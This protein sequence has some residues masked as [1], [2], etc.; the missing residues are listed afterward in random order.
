MSTDFF[1]IEI[2]SIQQETDEAVVLTLAIPPQLQQQFTYQPG[3]YITLLD[4]VNGEELRRSYSLC[5]APHEGCWQVGI[6]M[7]EGGKFSTYA[8]TQ[9]QPGHKLKAMPPTGKF[10]PK[11]A[12]AKHIMA[13]AAGSGITPCLSIIKHTLQNMPNTLVTL[14]YGNKNRYSILFKDEIEALKDKYLNR[15][16]VVYTLSKELTD[17]PLTSGRIDAT[18][19]NLLFHKVVQTQVDEYFIC[20]PEEMILDVK[21]FLEQKNVPASA[22]H[23]ELFGTTP[24]SKKQAK[25][26]VQADCEIEVIQDGR[27]IKFG[28]QN[29]QQTVLDAALANG[30]DL[31]FACK[32]G[33]CCTC[34]A[35]L[36]EGTVHMEV[37]YGLEDD[38]VAK[39]YILTCQSLPTSKKLVVSFDA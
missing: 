37:N 39:G 34:K 19:C 11:L 9:L 16:K 36:L 10:T 33:V 5:S 13:F 29:A 14:V 15:F 21:S 27:M 28:L 26:I 23:F 25:P 32:G 6:K 18:K 30:A 8:N 38:E 2:E 24:A 4:T 20:G 22:I 1:D 3:Q 35:K 12:Q 7:V 31:P 17:S